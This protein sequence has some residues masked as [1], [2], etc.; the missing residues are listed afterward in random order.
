MKHPVSITL[1]LLAAF[2]ATGC[3][4]S[5][6]ISDDVKQDARSEYNEARQRDIHDEYYQAMRE[7][8]EML[9]QQREAARARQEAA[10]AARENQNP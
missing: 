3:V 1:V 5:D 9:E 6:N 2:V 4:S 7:R 8:Q 10:Q